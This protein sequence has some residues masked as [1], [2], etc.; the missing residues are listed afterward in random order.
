MNTDQYV[1]HTRN[2]RFCF[3]EFIHTQVKRHAHKNCCCEKNKKTCSFT[4]VL[5]MNRLVTDEEYISH[6]MPIL[7]TLYNVMQSVTQS[8]RSK[9]GKEFEG[10]VSDILT[11]HHIPHMSQVYVCPDTLTFSYTKKGRS[12]PV[13]IVI[14]RPP[15]G[16]H[17][18]SYEIVSCKTKLRERYLQDKFLS[19]PYTLISL[20]RLCA[21]DPQINMIHVHEHGNALDVWVKNLKRKYNQDTRDMDTLHVLDLFC[22]C[23][24]FSYGLT[25]AGLDM[26]MGVDVW[27]TAIETYTTNM[28]HIGV[29]KDLT[30]FSPEE[31]SSYLSFPVDILVGGPPCQSFSIA[32]R[33]DRN[34]PRGSL[35]ME[36][37]KYLEYFKPKAFLFENVVGILSMKTESGEKVIDIILDLLG[38]E[39]TCVHSALYA[40]DYEVPQNRRRVI[41]MGI[42]KDLNVTPSFPP[43]VSV[44]RIPVSSILEERDVVGTELFLSQKALDGIQRKRERMKKEKKGFGAQILNPDKPSFT[45][46]ARYWKDGYD[47]LVKYS[48]TEIRRLS[49]T[50]I[51]RIQTFPDSYILCGT[52]KDQVMQLGNAVPCRFAFHLGRHLKTLLQQ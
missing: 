46:P 44:Q 16:A 15:D 7:E 42:R 21:P 1:L 10:L 17:I 2:Q 32:G 36:Y 13:D 29:C 37:V 43:V 12:H 11:Q 48:D 18:R 50:E 34:D 38:K 14:P 33:R 35:F 23:G 8:M 28:S 22:G 6:V 31:C 45:I 30:V 4:G 5:D 39:Y 25:Q 26:M 19:V 40:S 9:T 24:G 47:A 27:K 20:D 3:Q 51:K 49:L 52:K 41:I